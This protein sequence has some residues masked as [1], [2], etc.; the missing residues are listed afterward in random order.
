MGFLYSEK[1]KTLEIKEDFQTQV[2]TL[3]ISMNMRHSNCTVLTVQT[4]FTLYM[5]RKVRTNLI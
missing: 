2:L 3:N 4:H 1:Q 5:V